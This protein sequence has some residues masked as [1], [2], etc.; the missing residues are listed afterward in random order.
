AHRHIGDIKGISYFT[1]MKT[2]T[3]SLIVLGLALAVMS[4]APTEK[5]PTE[6]ELL[7]VPFTST[8]DQQEHEYFL[9][10]QRGYRDDPARKWPVMMFL[11]GNGERGNG[12]DELDFVLIHGPLYEAWI[13]RR[14]LPFIIISPQLPMFGMDTLGID[15]LT[16]RDPNRI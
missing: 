4:C 8:L 10:L 14:D 12:K 2:S 9:Y 5:A 1:F 13:Q 16:N 15:Y 6:E 11:H 7:R 3:G